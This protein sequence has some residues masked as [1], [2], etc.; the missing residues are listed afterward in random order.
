MEFDNQGCQFDIF[1]TFVRV[2]QNFV[3]VFQSVESD[4]I[5]TWA[6]S[7]L[8]ENQKPTMFGALISSHGSEVG[9]F[10][11]VVIEDLVLLGTCFTM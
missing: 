5:L 8:C 2:H 10:I 3:I 4:I 6:S 11:S 9:N 7:F 1:M